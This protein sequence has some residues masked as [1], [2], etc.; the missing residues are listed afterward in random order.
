MERAE[1]D[2]APEIFNE[3]DGE[4][5]ILSAEN[6]ILYMP[7]ITKVLFAISQYHDLK[8]NQFFF[9]VIELLI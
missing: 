4:F 3:E 9:C 2:L 7:S 5:E 1:D 6:N 8:F